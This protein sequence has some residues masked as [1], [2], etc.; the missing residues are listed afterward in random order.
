MPVFIDVEPLQP[1]GGRRRIQRL[2]VAQ[3]TGS[4]IVGPARG[5]FFVGSGDVAGERAGLFRDPMRF[6]ILLPKTS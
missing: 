4:A 2:M 1:E 6:I 3:D 5:D